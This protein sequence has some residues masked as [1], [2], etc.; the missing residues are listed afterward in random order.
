[1]VAAEHRRVRP[2]IAD[3]R[4]VVVASFNGVGFEEIVLLRE[5]GAVEDVFTECLATNHFK[6]GILGHAEWHELV[7]LYF[8]HEWYR[9]DGR[10]SSKA[11]GS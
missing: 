4:L 10:G 3:T 1:M 2:H 11:G 8:L 6:I 5:I 9:I 7:G